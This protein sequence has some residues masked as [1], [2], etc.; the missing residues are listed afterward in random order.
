MPSETSTAPSRYLLFT[1]AEWAALRA[2]A[3]LTLGEHDLARIRGL[4][5]SVA[6]DEVI[7]IYLPLARLLDLH[8][9]ASQVLHR[10]TATF[11]NATTTA[12]YVIGLAGSVAVGKSTTARILREL[13]SRWPGH[14][15]VDLVTTD[16]F[17][18][19]NAILE[20]RG[21]MSRKGFPESYDVRRL[22]RFLLDLKSGVAEAAAPVYSHTVYD[23]VP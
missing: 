16:G 5:E 3:P 15:R 22:V 19:P 10:A 12:P 13:L 6:L 11:L 18:F 8:I 20:A 1:R 9:G 2:D 17:L 7:D 4:N 14:P 21:L 23:I